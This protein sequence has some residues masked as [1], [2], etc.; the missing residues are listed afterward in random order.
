[1]CINVTKDLFFE[2]RAIVAEKNTRSCVKTNQMRNN[3][4]GDSLGRLVRQWC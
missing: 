3:V 1:M 2:L 4:M